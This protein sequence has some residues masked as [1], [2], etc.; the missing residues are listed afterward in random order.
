MSVWRVAYLLV[1]AINSI[2]LSA[3]GITYESPAWWISVL[4]VVA[5]HIVGR[6]YQDHVEEL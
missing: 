6:E 3:A 2:A 4:C 1:C 5:S